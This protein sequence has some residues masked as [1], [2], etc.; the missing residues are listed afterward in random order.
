MLNKIGRKY[1]E[2]ACATY[3]TKRAYAL[4]EFMLLCTK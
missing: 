3:Y 1:I 4:K 2:S